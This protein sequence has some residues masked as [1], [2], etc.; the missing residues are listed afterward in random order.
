MI[1]ELGTAEYMFPIT[2]DDALRGVVFCD[3]GTVEQD[4][5]ISN[6]RAAPGVGLR[7]SIPAMGP[8]RSHSTWPSRSPA[9]PATKFRTSASAWALHGS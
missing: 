4:V 3:F 6:F 9:H 2:A 8:R 5:R 1:Y 7:I